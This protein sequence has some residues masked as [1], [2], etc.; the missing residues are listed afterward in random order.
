[1]PVPPYSQ[2]SAVLSVPGMGIPLTS[3]V[4]V[5]PA[6]GVSAC[7]YNISPSPRPIAR[8]CVYPPA[9]LT[10]PAHTVAALLASSRASPLTASSNSGLSSSNLCLL[11]LGDDKFIIKN[12]K[13]IHINEQIKSEF[14]HK[15]DSLNLQ[16]K[17]TQGNISIDP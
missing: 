16:T 3:T 11:Y 13:F 9:G 1:M 10:W 12:P 17:Q 2:P 4:N 6:L 7:T 8:S 15:L 14:K 5:P